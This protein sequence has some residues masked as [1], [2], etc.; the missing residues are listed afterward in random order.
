ML[1]HHYN[2]CRALANRRLQSLSRCCPIV[3][4]FSSLLSVAIR[5]EDKNHWERRVPLTPDHVE[6]LVKDVGAK[7]YVQPSS[8]RVFPDSKYE[9]AGAVLQEDLSPADIILGVKEVP[10][11]S[12]IPDKTYLFFSHTHKG[13]LFISYREK[14]FSSFLTHP[15]GKV[16]ICPC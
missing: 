13:P 10:V 3:K 9:S 8:K 12:L 6:R 16:T 1:Q 11:N 4:P 7:V 15:K 14:Y 5:R 2:S